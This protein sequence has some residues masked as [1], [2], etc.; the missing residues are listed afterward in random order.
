MHRR[1]GID[2]L[3]PTRQSG[4]RSV[5]SRSVYLLRPAASSLTWPGLSTQYW[6]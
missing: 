4:T 6:L 5:G 1:G 3:D 2:L